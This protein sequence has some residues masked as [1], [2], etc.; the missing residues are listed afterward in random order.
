MPTPSNTP[1]TTTGGP[2]VQNPVLFAQLTERQAMPQISQAI[3]G[4]NK[5][6]RLQIEKVGVIAKVRL[7][8]TIKFKTKAGKEPVLNPGYPFKSLKEVALQSNGTTGIIDCSAPTLQQRR[9]RVY[10]NAVSA[11]QE[12]PAAGTKLEAAKAYKSVFVVEIPIAHDMESLIGALLAQN[13][14]TQLSFLLSWA[15]EEELFSLAASIEEFE[16]TVEWGTVVF[17]IGSSTVGGKEVVVLPDLTAFHGLIEKEVNLT[18]TG[19]QP[20]ELFRTSGQL[21]CFTAAVT[22][23]AGGQSCLSPKEWTKFAIEYGGNKDPLVWEP[24]SELLEQNADEY[25]GP[26]TVG[27]LEFLALDLEA[28]N[29]ERD[30]LIPESL[31]ELRSVI[32]IPA[33]FNPENA[34]ILNSQET[35]YPAV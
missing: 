10:R 32:G 7:K 24:A 23:K 31:V 26:L 13:E 4:L 2:E 34:R 15:D 35:L 12:G 30:M 3:A 25:D 28:D 19:K 6:N 1:A 16:G 29:T 5:K 18:G 8:I 9:Q 11:L 33:A 20:T 21:L 14:E 22:N 27:G 17:S